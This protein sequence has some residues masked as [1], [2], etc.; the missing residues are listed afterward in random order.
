MIVYDMTKE[1]RIDKLLVTTGQ[2]VGGVMIYTITVASLVYHT[3]T[4]LSIGR[5]TELL[6]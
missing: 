2:C 4:P 6:L 5:I 3:P 1:K